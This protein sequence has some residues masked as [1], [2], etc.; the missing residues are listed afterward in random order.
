M[1]KISV[2]IPVYKVEQY[3]CQC[4]DS[5]LSQTFTNY[6]CILVDDGSPDNCPEI[7]DKYA[8]KDRRFKVIHKEN[9]GLSDARNAGITVAIGDYVVLL[10]GD[11][12]FADN[13]ALNNL[14][15]VINKNHPAVVFNSHCSV[16]NDL[17][18][19]TTITDFIGNGR[20][21]F[22]PYQFYR[23]ITN[24]KNSLIAAWLF[25]VKKSF[26]IEHQLFFRKGLLHEDTLWIAQLICSTNIIMINNSL[27]YKYRINRKGSIMSSIT[28]KN[29]RD[30]LLIL[31]I[32][33]EHSENDMLS[34]EQKIFLQYRITQFWI[35]IFL[36]VTNMK[37]IDNKEIDNSEYC[38]ILT[39]LKKLRWVLFPG[40]KKLKYKLFIVLLLLF[41]INK[42]SFLLK[43]ASRFIR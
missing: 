4:L 18:N 43:S 38:N 21:D 2:I 30:M 34:K 40:A 15:T 6:E 10:D 25:C 19:V 20:T 17:D 39:E 42:M 37:E 33:Q 14:V 8:K 5:V 32:F 28:I 3:L 29:I 12:L 35:R 23:G 1:P 26:L 31:K 41:G 9:G 7:C 13:E 22:T 27:F 36:L 11:D 24:K 16:I